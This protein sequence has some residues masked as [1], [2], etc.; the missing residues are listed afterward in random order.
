[1]RFKFLNSSTQ[2]GKHPN[3]V[4]DVL[5]RSY[6]H[7]DEMIL[8]NSLRCSK[9]DWSKQKKSQTPKSQNLVFVG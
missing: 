5:E 6:V 3:W 1:M 4:L 8:V 7:L 2:G 9:Y